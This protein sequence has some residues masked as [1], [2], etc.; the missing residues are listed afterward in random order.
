L[1]LVKTLL[2]TG[3]GLQAA[4]GPETARSVGFQPNL[5]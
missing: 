3:S 4:D 2:A 5:V 1:Q